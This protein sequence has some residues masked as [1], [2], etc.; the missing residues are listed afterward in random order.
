MT[1]PRR[2]SA[3][4]Q[5]PAGSC[6]RPFGFHGPSADD[7]HRAYLYAP[8]SC[9]ALNHCS[10]RACRSTLQPGI[11]AKPLQAPA[12]I[13][14]FCVVLIFLTPIQ[15]A[16]SKLGAPGSPLIDFRA[17]SAPSATAEFLGRD[18]ADFARDAHPSRLC[19]Q[20]NNEPLVG[21]C[22]FHKCKRPR[23]PH[24]PRLRWQHLSCH[25]QCRR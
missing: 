18:R 11:A 8:P 15:S 12:N 13:H 2:S 4:L 10:G 9:H 14:L 20:I 25:P 22:G 1:W 21:A 23:R 3:R 7:L 6:F 24:L 5:V 19:G 17:E 16:M